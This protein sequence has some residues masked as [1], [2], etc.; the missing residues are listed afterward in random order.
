MPGQMSS[1]FSRRLVS[2]GWYMPLFTI[3]SVA[4]STQLFTTSASNPAWI[5]ATASSLLPNEAVSSSMFGYI[6]KN[7]SMYSGSNPSE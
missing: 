6:S 1:Q 3:S 7:V 5:F 2:S 4:S